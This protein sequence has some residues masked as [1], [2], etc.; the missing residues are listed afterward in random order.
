VGP[1]SVVGGEEVVADGADV[2]QMGEEMGVQH[3]GA[4]GPVEALMK[5]FC[6]GLPGSM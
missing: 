3:F 2:V 1:L 6:C 4:V 5:A